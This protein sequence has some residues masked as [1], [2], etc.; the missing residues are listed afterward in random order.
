[1][2]SIGP[3]G[4]FSCVANFLI[5]ICSVV[6]ENKDFC[7]LH[8]MDLF[9]IFEESI[10]ILNKSTLKSLEAFSS[11]PNDLKERSLQSTERNLKEIERIIKQMELE[12]INFKKTKPLDSNKLQKVNS[13]KNELENFKKFHRKNKDIIELSIKQEKLLSVDSSIN[14]KKPLIE[15]DR[16]YF[17]QS[18]KIED[19]KRKAIEMESIS[20]EIMNK[21]QN[22]NDKM[23]N[24]NKKVNTLNNV[25]LDTSNQI[26]KRM[27]NK[28][29]RNR[30]IIFGTSIFLILFLIIFI[31]GRRF[32]G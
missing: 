2:I 16:L 17:N 7:D 14:I 8:K 31:V 32:Y 13:Y 21:L 12:L 5:L 6:G 22:N 19:G 18:M 24:I 4:L 1:V 25:E 15:T 10:Q 30:L 3:V 28:M 20:I 9:P 23:L 27:I 11:I 29:A 26:L